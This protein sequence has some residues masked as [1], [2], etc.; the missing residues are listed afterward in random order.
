MKKDANIMR[1]VE[2]YKYKYGIS[3]ADEKSN[4]VKRLY[5]FAKIVLIYMIGFIFV[6]NASLLF[7]SQKENFS[8]LHINAS[9]YATDF[10][11]LAACFV[12]LIAALILAKKNKLFIS[13]GLILPVAVECFK[14]ATQDGLNYMTAFY[15]GAIPAYVA[16]L[17]IAALVFIII[18]A[19]LKTNG[20]YSMIIDILYKQY[21]TK[22]GE[23]LTEE[24]WQ[25]FLK[26]YDSKST[27]LDD[28]KE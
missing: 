15:L 20:I 16:V 25:S 9:A 6:F 12:L 5:F 17:L 4:L 10:Y 8:F 1:Y 21:G 2:K 26:S 27:I 13:I 3:Y 7:N 14:P 22:D 19:K 23:K 11:V 18:R 24:Q 28:K